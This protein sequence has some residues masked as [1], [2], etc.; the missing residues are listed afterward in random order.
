M[1]E[2]ENNPEVLNTNNDE[3]V[4]QSKME[5]SEVMN[6]NSIEP[7]VQNNEETISEV[8]LDEIISDEIANSKPEEVTEAPE[9]FSDMEN[10]ESVE[11]FEMKEGEHTEDKVVETTSPDNDS[12]AIEVHLEE[13]PQNSEL[14]DTIIDVVQQEDEEENEETKMLDEEDALNTDYSAHTKSQLLNLAVDAPRILAPREAVKRIQNIRPFFD[15]ILKLERQENLQKHLEAGNE[16]DTFE[17]NDEGSRLKFYDAF[18]MAQESRSEEKKRIEDEKVKN[19]AAKNAIIERIKVLTESD[20]TTHSLDEIKQLQ[21]DWKAIRVVPKANLQELYDRY[22]FYLDKFYDNFAINRELKELDKQKNLGVKIDLCNKVDALQ[23]EVSLKRAFI[24]LAKYQEE[25]KNTG[26]VPKEFSEEIWSR[27]KSTIDLIY[28]QRKGQFEEIQEKRV[29][30]LK[31]KEVLVEKSRLIVNHIP[32]KNSEWK[33]NFEELNKLMEEWKTIGQVPKAQNE[34]IWQNFREQFSIFSKNRNEQYKHANAERKANIAVKEN[35]CKRAEELK[36]SEDIVNTTK[37]LI[38][39]QEE[40][41]TSGQVPENISHSLWKRFRAACD[42]FFNRK[43]SMFEE[44]KGQETTN[45][46]LKKII[47]AEMT[48]LQKSE[49]GDEVLS[50]LRDIQSRW[51]EIG[52][53]PLKSKKE[54]GD[55]YH[56]LLDTLYKK[57]RQNRDT[58]KQAHLKEHYNQIATM[59][60]GDKK[61]GDDERRLREKING[62]KSEIETWE[63]NIEFFARSKNADKL[64]KDIEEK[65][66]RV[67]LQIDGMKKE[68]VA[69]RAAKTEK[70]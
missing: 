17:Y 62:L 44:R 22:H 45:L 56:N 48:E 60:G 38:K 59:P 61:L 46:E 18:K 8:G 19:L 21:N 53:V 65:I 3:V 20:E 26:P 10:I 11:N 68:L 32:T 50:K 24:L 27:F 13:Q 41:K 37:E 28:A 15:T 35:L 43:Q 25:F 55:D 31:L 64:K 67:N 47:I 54:I 6:E 30:N 4:N 16:E 29:E 40:W 23:K 66:A 42:A 58:H 69:L 63:N 7:S 52:F 14:P 57:F 1:S 34:S 2:Q 70:V 12:S 36:D 49:D 33:T 51:N 5:N 9:S 39:L